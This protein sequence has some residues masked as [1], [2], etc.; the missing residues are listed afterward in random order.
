MF[1]RHETGSWWAARQPVSYIHT[2]SSF[3]LQIFTHYHKQHRCKPVTHAN[4]NS[5][6]YFLQGGLS[7]HDHLVNQASLT[8]LAPA[9]S[10]R[11]IRIERGEVETLSW[12]WKCLRRWNDVFLQRSDIWTTESTCVYALVSLKSYYNYKV[13]LNCCT[14]HFDNIKIL[15]TNKYTNLLNT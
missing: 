10:C 4:I 8:A 12:R 14:V 3:A 11:S 5:D 13:F 15:F 2:S 9:F 1:T 6:K 7:V